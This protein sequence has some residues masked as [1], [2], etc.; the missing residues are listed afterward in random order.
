[1]LLA[2]I[3]LWKTSLDNKNAFGALW[4]DLSMAFDCVNHELFIAKLQTYGLDFNSLKLIHSC[5][6]NKR[7]RK[8]GINNSFSTASESGYAVL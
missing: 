1:M 5:Y 2:L 6:V 7:K 3:K 4:P 8:V